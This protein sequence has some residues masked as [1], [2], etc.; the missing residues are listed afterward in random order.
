MD[1]YQYLP[2]QDEIEILH[3]EVAQWWNKLAQKVCKRLHTF[4]FAGF[5]SCSFCYVCVSRLLP[6]ELTWLCEKSTIEIT[7]L[8]IKIWRW[9]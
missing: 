5:P 1:A 6:G 4:L 3:I 7:G 8:L 2:L 9:L